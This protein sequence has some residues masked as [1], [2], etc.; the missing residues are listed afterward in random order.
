[1]EFFQKP[2]EIMDFFVVALSLYFELAKDTF[3]AGVLLLSRT[4]R[5]VRV[6]HGMVELEHEQKVRSRYSVCVLCV[7]YV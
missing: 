6:I 7:L 2:M 4:W 1:M 5:F 3:A